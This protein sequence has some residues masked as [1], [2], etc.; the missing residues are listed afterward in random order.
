MAMGSPSLRMTGCFF[1]VPKL[2][3]G[4]R[5]Q[6]LDKPE[7]RGKA[8]PMNGEQRADL[9]Y[10][11]GIRTRL[12]F[13]LI[14]YLIPQIGL[15]AF[16]LASEPPEL[17]RVGQ[18]LLLLFY[19][20]GLFPWLPV[21]AYLIYLVNLSVSCCVTSRRNFKIAMIVLMILGVLDL[22]GCCWF[23]TVIG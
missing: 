5:L 12:I 4:T 22:G 2:R 13:W 23:Y 8:W 17:R 15:M 1:L 6:S 11:P 14:I 3:L 21:V 7:G 19:P 20:A 18:L 9:P 10:E 16:I